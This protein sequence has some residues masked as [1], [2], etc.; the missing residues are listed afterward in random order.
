MVVNRCSLLCPDSRNLNHDS[1][2]KLRRGLWESENEVAVIGHRTW[3]SVKG[4]GC[5]DV[6][7]MY[8]ASQGLDMLKVVGISKAQAAQRAGRAGREGPGFVYRLY[9]ESVLAAAPDFHLPEILRF[10]TSSSSLFT[11][12]H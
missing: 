9:P 11:S 12:S 4:V 3:S 1:R 2:H 7:R 10:L 5:V 6:P 8:E